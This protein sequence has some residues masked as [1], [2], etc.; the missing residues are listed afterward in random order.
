M[1]LSFYNNNSACHGRNNNNAFSITTFL[2]TVCLIY[3]IAVITIES[4]VVTS[5]SF[6][7]PIITRATSTSTENRKTPDTVISIRRS[8]S[9]SF[10]LNHHRNHIGMGGFFQIKKKKKIQTSPPYLL[11]QLVSYHHQLQHKF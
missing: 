1:I 11:N 6:S 3:F 4:V 9:S 8:S 7:Q 5:F 2:S 10:V